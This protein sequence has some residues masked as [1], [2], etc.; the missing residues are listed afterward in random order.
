MIRPRFF[1]PEV[2]LVLKLFVGVMLASAFLVT[3]AWGYEQR[4]QAHVWRE[5]ACSFRMADVTRQAPFLA[6]NDAPRDACGRL[7]ALGVTLTY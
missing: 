7:D 1:L 5:T 6:Q 3:L 2:E 4:R